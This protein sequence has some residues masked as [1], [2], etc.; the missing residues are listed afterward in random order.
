M[1]KELKKLGV[2]K[3]LSFTGIVSGFKP[4]DGV[5]RTLIE[6]VRYKGKTI[7]DHVWLHLGKDF[8]SLHFKKGDYVRFNSQIISYGKMDKTN[9]KQ[10]KLDYGLSNPI[11][12]E[13][14]DEQ[15]HFQS[16]KPG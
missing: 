12:M 1:R 3:R 2:G 16:N 9:K 10:K 7:T 13:I 6:D 8:S 11:H 14:I 4:F 5:T 15:T